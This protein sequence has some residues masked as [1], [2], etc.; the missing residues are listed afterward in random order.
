MRLRESR[1]R[2][3]TIPLILALVLLIVVGGCTSTKETNTEPTTF[4]EIDTAMTERVEREGL[5]GAGLLVV[6]DGTEFR[7]RTYGGYSN[8]TVIPIASAS[9]WL[10]AATMM[11]L[12]DEGRVS[13]ADPISKYLPEFTGASGSATI[14]QL[15]SHTSG[16]AQAPCVWEERQ[17]LAQCVQTVATQKPAS[18]PGTRFSYGNTSYSVAGRIIEVVTGRTFQQAFEE[19]I[20]R[21][22]G[23]THTR[24][25]GNY[26]PT[27]SH[28]V[29]AA[30][31]ESTLEDYGRFLKMISDRGMFDGRRILSE[32]SVLAME[33]DQV[34]GLETGS[35]GAVRTTG[36]PTYGL[37][38]WRDVT[39]ADDIGV[40]TSGNGA[41]GFYPWVDRSRNGYGIVLVFDQRG[42]DLAVPESQ[43][44]MHWVLNALD[45]SGVPATTTATTVYRR[46]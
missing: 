28:P 20:A 8:G 21:P 35:D 46:R 29:P 3:H 32:Q 39:T 37:G 45:R 11:T 16:I 15:L 4:P 36:I 38:T 30:S 40:I 27:E 5:D 34:A 12:V 26:Y 18:A 23:M 41:Y 42:S 2:R 9:K 33:S 24:F 10:T 1:H 13:L 7:N 22:L 19:R 17:T 25:D 44:E 6:A 31:A 43:R 14:G